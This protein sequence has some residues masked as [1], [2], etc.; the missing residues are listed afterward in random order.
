MA[1]KVPGFASGEERKFMPESFGNRN[2]DDPVLVFIKT[3]TEREKREVMQTA[4]ATVGADGDGEIDLAASM[5]WQAAVI[6]KFVTRVAGYVASDGSTIDTAA[7]LV[8]HGETEIVSEVAAEILTGLSLSDEEKKHSV[9]LSDTTP[10]TTQATNG[11]AENV[12]QA[13]LQ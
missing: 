13:G 7:R 5:R 3:P 8:E 1:R 9:G 6:E 11:I 10:E 2:E 12:A 4:A